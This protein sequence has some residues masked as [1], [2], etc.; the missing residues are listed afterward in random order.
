MLT[1][2]NKNYNAICIGTWYYVQVMTIFNDNSSSTK[3]ERDPGKDLT[4][5]LLTFADSSPAN[6]VFFYRQFVLYNVLR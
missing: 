3:L 1:E 6:L 5:S 2:I 4:P